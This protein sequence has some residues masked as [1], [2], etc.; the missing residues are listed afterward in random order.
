MCNYEFNTFFFVG[1]CAPLCVG[2]FVTPDRPVRVVRGDGIC[3]FTSLA[4]ALQKSK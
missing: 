4:C 2:I 3:L 1:R